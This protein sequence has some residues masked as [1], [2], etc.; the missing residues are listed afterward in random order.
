[1]TVVGTYYSEIALFELKDDPRNHT[2]KTI[3]L[4]VISWI[5]LSQ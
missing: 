2:N 3:L 1:M 5:A 4:R